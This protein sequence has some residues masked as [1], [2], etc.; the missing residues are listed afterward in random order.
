MNQIHALLVT[1]P[2]QIRTT[3]RNLGSV[4]L[5]AALARSRTNPGHG[6]EQTLRGSLKRLAVRH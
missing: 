2:D 3:Y 4:K 6:P 1:A 5:I